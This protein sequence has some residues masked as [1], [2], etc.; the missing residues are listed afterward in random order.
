MRSNNIRDA[1][2]EAIHALSMHPSTGRLWAVIIHLGCAQT[3]DQLVDLIVSDVGVE[4]EH[5]GTEHDSHSSLAGASLT[6]LQ[7]LVF[8]RALRQVPKSGEVWCEGARIAIAEGKFA[9]ARK[10]LQFAV[11]FTPQYGDSFIEL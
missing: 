4:P 5:R 9:D 10:Y 8:A 2:K 3:R 1:M 6:H 7:S 11:Q